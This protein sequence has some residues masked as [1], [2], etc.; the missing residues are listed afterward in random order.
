MKSLA[1]VLLYNLPHN[2]GFTILPKLVS[3]V[4]DCTE[5]RSL[6]LIVWGFSLN[7]SEHHVHAVPTE[8]RRG[9][10]I[11]WSYRLFY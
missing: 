9:R 1:R 10:W 4:S 3:S 11:P 7:V 2:S 5:Q 6:I 8:D